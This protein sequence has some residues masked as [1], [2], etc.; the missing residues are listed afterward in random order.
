MEFVLDYAIFLLKA[1][2]IVIAIMI[3]ISSIASATMRRQ[4]KTDVGTLHIR[5][6]NEFYEQMSKAMEQSLLSPG[7]FKKRIKVE[8]KAKKKEQ[9]QEAKKKESATEDQEDTKDKTHVYVI[10]FVGDL[11]ASKVNTLRHEVSAVLSTAS[12]GDEVVVKIESSGGLVHSY[13][14]AASQLLRIKSAGLK[15]TVAIDQVAASGGYMLAVVADRILAAPFAVVGSIGVAAEIPNLHRFLKKYDI[16]YDVITAG[17]YK[18]TLTMF[19]ENTD[20]ARD[21]FVQEIEDVHALFREFVDTNREG[22]DLDAVSTGETWY[23]QRALDVKLVDEIM[24]SDQLIMDACKACKV[25]E[26]KWMM[27]KK[28]VGEILSEAASIVTRIGNWVTRG[29]K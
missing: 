23:G 21:R 1:V 6:L 17:D 7:E 9:K 5:S 26:V 18:R 27:P 28:K 4:S 19:G 8:R 22:L 16:D 2:T 14:L 25:F 10:E 20:A 12:E 15:L 3:V 11:E 24:T 29:Y 13:G